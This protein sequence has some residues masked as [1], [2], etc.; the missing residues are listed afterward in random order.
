MV[1]L[2]AD[3]TPPSYQSSYWKDGRSISG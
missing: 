2:K 3:T 1:R